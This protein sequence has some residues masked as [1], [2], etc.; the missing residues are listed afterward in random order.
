MPTTIRRKL[1]ALITAR[2]AVITALLGARNVSAV[3][4][5]DLVGV[6]WLMKRQMSH[7]DL[8]EVL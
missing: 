6:R 4:L 8:E 3:G 1:L 2:A 5:H 7:V